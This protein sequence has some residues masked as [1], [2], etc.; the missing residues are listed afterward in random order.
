MPSVSFQCFLGNASAF[1]LECRYVALGPW[2][3]CLADEMIGWTKQRS[4]YCSSKTNRYL[5]GRLLCLLFVVFTPVLLVSVASCWCWSL[6][7]VE[8][9]K[10]WHSLFIGSIQTKDAKRH[11]RFQ[12]PIFKN[13]ACFRFLWYSNGSLDIPS[14]GIG[15][16]AH[17][18]E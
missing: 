8:G 6:E 2:L 12:R 1:S 13:D 9:S 10:A 7:D 3:V 11:W 16:A 15:I 4:K 5:H 18:F 17:S 14:L